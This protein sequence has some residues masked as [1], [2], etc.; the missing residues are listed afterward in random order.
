MKNF[1]RVENMRAKSGSMNKVR[2][3]AGYFYDKNN[4]QIAF[5]IMANN[6]P[7]SA[8]KQK[9]LMIELL[10]SA[11]ENKFELPFPYAFIGTF[12]DTLKSL[13]EIINLKN[14]LKREPD[15]FFKEEERINEEIQFTF[16]GE[17]STEQ[18]YFK[19]IA[20]GGGSVREVKYEYRIHAQTRFAERWNPIKN[21]WEM[22]CW[23]DVFM[24]K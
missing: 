10:A 15:A 19:A 11:A 2:A 20:R 5:S 24:Q 16:A 7:I 23:G 12:T 8:S 9:E 4:H 14:E 13:P 1:P 17:P 22:I 18:P 6:A 3:Y 21:E